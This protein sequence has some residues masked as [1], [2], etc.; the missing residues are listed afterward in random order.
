MKRPIDDDRRRTGFVRVNHTGAMAPGARRRLAYVHRLATGRLFTFVG[1][2][3]PRVND[4]ARWHCAFGHLVRLSV[5]D[6]RRGV[7]C[8]TCRAIAQ[9]A[10]RERQL[11]D[12]QRI[13]LARH[14]A[15][16]S[17]RY[18][19]ARQVLEWRCF[20]GHTWKASLDNVRSKGSWCP[21]CARRLPRPGRRKSA[22]GTKGEGDR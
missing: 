5:K 22:R 7:N 8:A 3:A 21:V 16:L 9:E 11:E 1:H 6:V 2:A 14:G 19:S 17:T 15:C 13:A 4:V 10:F 12:A 20:D 18:A